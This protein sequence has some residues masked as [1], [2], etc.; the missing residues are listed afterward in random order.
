M[1]KGIQRSGPPMF[2]V[3][4]NFKS[5]VCLYIDSPEDLPSAA[6]T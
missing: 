5:A 4:K 3:I 6:L 1:M 2:H